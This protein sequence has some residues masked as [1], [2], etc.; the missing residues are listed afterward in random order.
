MPGYV[1]NIYS[2]MARVSAFVLSSAWEGFPSVLVEAMACGVPVVATDCPSGPFEILEGGRYG[3][4][5]P[6]GDPISLAEAL[7]KSLTAPAAVEAARLRA[8]QFAIDG[9][10]REYLPLLT[11]RR[12]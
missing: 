1:E 8:N 11:G 7:R 9:A 5:V 4:L 3:H 2:Y 10:V 6:V 12:S